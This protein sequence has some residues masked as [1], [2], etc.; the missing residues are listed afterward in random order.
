MGVVE[1]GR[2]RTLIPL[3]LLSQQKMNQYSQT[4]S[5]QD[6]VNNTHHLEIKVRRVASICFLNSKAIVITGSGSY[7]FSVPII[8]WI[9]SFTIF[10]RDAGRF[11]SAA[12][13]TILYSPPSSKT[14]FVSANTASSAEIFVCDKLECGG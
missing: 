10:K 7:T 12:R 1:S 14:E 11:I 2:A 5:Q 3:F 4:V 6:E 8:V 9:I 13:G